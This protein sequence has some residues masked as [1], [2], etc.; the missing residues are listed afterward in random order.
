MGAEG[1]G[2]LAWPG[3]GGEE[4]GPGEGEMVETHTEGD[5]KELSQN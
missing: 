2:G 4:M 5:Q 3:E 1:G